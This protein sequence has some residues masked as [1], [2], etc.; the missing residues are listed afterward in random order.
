MKF[1]DEKEILKSP[2]EKTFFSLEVKI[3]TFRQKIFFSEKA[4]IHA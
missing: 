1:L 4:D 3:I 2:K